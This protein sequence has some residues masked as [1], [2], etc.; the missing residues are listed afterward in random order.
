MPMRKVL[1]I[2]LNG[3]ART[4]RDKRALALFLLMPMMLIGIL[5]AA[6]K[7]MLSG[8][9]INPFEV[10]V[11]NA[12]APARPPVASGTPAFA[13]ARFP[14]FH[15][16]KILAE[17][18]LTGDRVR[19]VMRVAPATDLEKAKSDVSAGKAAAVVYVPPTFTADAL[20]G[21]P[22]TVQVFSDPGRP[23]QADIVSQVVRS[24]T[25]SVASGALLGRIQGLDGARKFQTEGSAGSEALDPRGAPR[26]TEV[27]SGARPVSAI[28]Y[29]SAAMAIMFMVMTALARAKDI[30]RERQEGTLFRM[31]VSPTSRATVLAGQILGSVALVLAQFIVLML[32]TRFLFGVYWGAWLPALLLGAAFALA[33]AGIGTAAAGLLNDPR[34]ADASIGLVGN[35]F[36]ALSGG[37]FPIY[38]F[39]EGLKLVAKFIPNYWALQGFLDQMAGVGL[40][41]LWLPVAVLVAMGMAT[42][43]IGAWRLASK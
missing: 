38:I 37:M 20:A 18:I 29:Y 35:I 11:V 14:T 26:L 23:V 27:P 2:A 13:P 19:E 17:E 34:S 21:R 9:R 28:Q 33:A 16:G 41:S 5:G 7:G 12:D 32:G 22:A 10:I 43:G 15:F 3:L 4:A 39:P 8:G 1:A 30:M 40:S 42:G 36:G 31:L 24:F 25:D 6:L